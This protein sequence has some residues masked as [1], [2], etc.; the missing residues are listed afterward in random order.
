MLNRLAKAGLAGKLAGLVFLAAVP[1]SALETPADDRDKMKA[2]EKQLCMIVLK[3]ETAGDDLKCD[4]GRTWEKSQIVDG[5]KEKKISWTFGDARCTI[6]VNLKRQAIVDAMTRP[7]YDL[8][9]DK[10]TFKCKIE[11]SEGITDVNVDAAPKMSFKGGK[12]DK[13]WLNVSNIEAPTLIKGAIWT[14][15]KLEDNFGLFHSEMV[16]ETNKLITQRCAKN[17]GS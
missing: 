14:A 16:K 12:V 17:Y 8:V 9:A 3:K 7:S 5:V 4:I 15:A 11:R 1:A 13:I 2:C 10:H 6:N